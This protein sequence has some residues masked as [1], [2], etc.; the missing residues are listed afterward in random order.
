MKMLRGVEYR[1]NLKGMSAAQEKSTCVGFTAGMQKLGKIALVFGRTVLAHDGW[2]H[3]GPE[4]YPQGTLT[5]TAP[6]PA[7]SLAAPRLSLRPGAPGQPPLHPP[8]P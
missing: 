6:H 5:L 4:A 7:P 1:L 3:R 8:T 2:V